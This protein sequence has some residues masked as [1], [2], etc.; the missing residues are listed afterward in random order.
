M[1]ELID[2]GEI[3]EEYGFVIESEDQSR[4]MGRNIEEWLTNLLGYEYFVRAN[5][6]HVIIFARG[7]KKNHSLGDIDLRDCFNRIREELKTN[8]VPRRQWVENLLNSKY[9]YARN[10]I[11]NRAVSK[12]K[13]LQHTVMAMR[14]DKKKDILGYRKRYAINQIK[15]IQNE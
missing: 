2:R 13:L 14:A 8:R 9:D 1:Q 15:E 5:D 7:I 6:T 4:E 10:I 11:L 3:R 12:A